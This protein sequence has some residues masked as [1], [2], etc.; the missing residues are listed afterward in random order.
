MWLFI[1]SLLKFVV[2]HK[3]YVNSNDILREAMEEQL[4]PNATTL[5]YSESKGSYTFC[6]VKT[7]KSDD[8]KAIH[9]YAKN[10]THVDRSNTTTSDLISELKLERCIF[11]RDS[12][13]SFVII[14]NT[15]FADTLKKKNIAEGLTRD[16]L[17]SLHLFESE[18]YAWFYYSNELGIFNL[19]N[20][21]Y[22]HKHN[23]TEYITI[24]A[25][26]DIHPKGFIQKFCLF[27]N[28]IWIDYDLIMVNQVMFTF[29]RNAGYLRNNVT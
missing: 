10:T 29:T 26:D 21:D 22:F 14:K 23:V 24:L 17:K 7:F 3:T 11:D 6:N 13:F 16:Y 20:S 25:V 28:N 1:I 9:Q 2:Y 19:A 27:D 8:S 5:P 18:Q 4:L 12:L 15:G